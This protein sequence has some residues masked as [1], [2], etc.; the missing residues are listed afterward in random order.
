MNIGNISTLYLLELVLRGSAKSGWY[1]ENGHVPGRKMTIGI[2]SYHKDTNKINYLQVAK[3]MEVVKGELEKLKGVRNVSIGIGTG[4]W[5]GGAEPT[6]RLSYNGNG[7][8]I[9]YLAGYGKKKG[10]DGVLFMKKSTKNNPKAQPN[11][12]LTFDKPIS[13]RK[14][15][16]VEEIIVR[17]IK[18]QY[19]G[20][21]N[22]GWTWGKKNG[23]RTLT[24]QCVPAWG[25]EKEKHEKA[26]L[27]VMN[28]LKSRKISHS[29][30]TN[31][32]EV[33][34]ADMWDTSENNY[35]AIINGKSPFN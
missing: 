7:E 35:D 3:D 30:T 8:A 23:K 26:L 19:N 1:A 11:V 27:E 17:K 14:R 24:S 12:Q 29:N 25:G 6:M 34:T 31:Y 2:T 5:D 28:E 15:K 10:Q 32:N 16:I 13:S 9:R 22:V 33:G 21:P 18:E 20:Q 4:G